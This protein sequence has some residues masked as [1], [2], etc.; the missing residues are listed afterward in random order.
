MLAIRPRVPL[1][2]GQALTLIAVVA[3]AIPAH[4]AV[5][6]GKYTL[7][8]QSAAGSRLDATDKSRKSGTQVQIWKAAGNPNQS[9]LLTS[10]G[11]GWYKIHPSYDKALDLGVSGNSAKNG[12]AV[13]LAGD[14]SST[15]ELWSLHSTNGG[16][17]LAPKC[18][19]GSRLDVTGW[20]KAD[21]TKLQIWTATGKPNQTWVLGTK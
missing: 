18:A 4:G 14:N 10:L 21:G 8:P 15:G 7:A 20:S 12:A 5:K 2:L 1:P 9:W 11:G 16:Y 3:A 13:V 6:S 19:P 17:E